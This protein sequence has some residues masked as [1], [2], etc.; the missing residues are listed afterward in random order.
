VDRTTIFAAADQ[1]H[2][3]F[4][5]A[6][7]ELT[8]AWSDLEVV[9]C[10]V[11]MRY[12]GVDDKVGRAIFSG[13]RAAGMI[14][15]ILAIAENTSMEAARLA[16]LE[17]LFQQ[18][19]SINTMRDFIVHHVNGSETEFQ[20]SNPSE[21]VLTDDRRAGRPTKAKTV[22]VGSSSLLAMRDDLFECCWRFHAHLRLAN[23][24]F[25]PGSGANGK[26]NPW[27][28]KPPQPQR[29]RRDA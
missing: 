2:E 7:G 6:I 15:F 10:K 20:L 29:R 23:D 14:K 18:I 11:L 5:R 26:R 27:R 25:Q 8:L 1:E 4:L 3:A 13:T 21:R 12:A 22:L 28:Y 16:D 9:L 24:P 17:H 19:K